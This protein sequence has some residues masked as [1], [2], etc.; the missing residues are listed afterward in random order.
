MKLRFLLFVVTLVGIFLRQMHK[1]LTLSP[2]ATLLVSQIIPQPL[3][4]Y[5][6]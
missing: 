1:H 6:H 5:P 4:E 3:S 2:F